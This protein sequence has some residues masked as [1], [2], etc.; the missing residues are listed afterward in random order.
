[1]DAGEPPRRFHATTSRRPGQGGP[2]GAV[3]PDAWSVPDQDANR[4]ARWHAF[5]SNRLKVT[6]S[7]PVHVSR[8][9]VS[10]LLPPGIPTGARLLSAKANGGR[11][12]GHWWLSGNRSCCR[13]RAARDTASQK[14]VLY[15][16]SRSRLGSPV[17]PPLAQSESPE[18]GQPYL[19]CCRSVNRRRGRAAC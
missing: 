15:C 14:G 10:D 19:R 2:R 9:G 12:L 5:I 8:A 13:G 16:S 6:A 4:Q 7:H 18:A 3:R 1:M 17:R 11:A